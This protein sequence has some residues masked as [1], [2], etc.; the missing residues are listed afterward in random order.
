M[1]ARL[2]VME[3]PDIRKL[4]LPSGILATVADLSSIVPETFQ[5]QGDYSLQ[6]MDIEFGDHCFS[7]TDTDD[8]KNKD[9]IKVVYLV[10]PP[11]SIYHV[12]GWHLLLWV[13]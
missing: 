7:L 1:L 8:I 12:I 6:Y 10:A 13:P 3:N 2:Q 9:T 4:V 5:L 11:P